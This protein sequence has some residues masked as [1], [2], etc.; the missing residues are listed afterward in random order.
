M[1]KLM[2]VLIIFRVDSVL[3]Q[4]SRKFIIN[5]YISFEKINVLYEVPCGANRITF[6]GVVRIIKFFDVL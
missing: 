1:S 3:N 2:Q 5:Y 6:S 4:S